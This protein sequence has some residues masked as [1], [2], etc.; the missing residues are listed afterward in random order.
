MS[1][2][3]RRESAG[4]GTSLIFLAAFM[5]W[6]HPAVA[7]DRATAAASTCRPAAFATGLLGEATDARTFVLDDGR[8]VRLAGIESPGD[9]TN[10][11]AGRARLQSLLSGRPLSLKRFDSERD[12]YGRRLAYVYRADD[13]LFVNARL[14]R[15]GYDTVLTIPPNV[16][17][18]ERFR[19]QAAE[20]RRAGRG[21]WSA[22]EQ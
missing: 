14:V 9:D 6:S 8:E 17:F 19:R 20:A 18:A 7:E 22:C 12:R 2:Q 13:G 21:L 11:A 15:N 1:T 16:R 10:T 5:T 3:A 4:G